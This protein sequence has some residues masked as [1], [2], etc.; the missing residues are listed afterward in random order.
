MPSLFVKLELWIEM[1]KAQWVLQTGFIYTPFHENNALHMPGVGKAIQLC[2]L[3]KYNYWEDKDAYFEIH[4]VLKKIKKTQQQE[5]V[6]EF[7]TQ[8]K[9]F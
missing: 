4:W 3:K 1:K 8:Q 2:H 6:N 5:F 7:I 9:R